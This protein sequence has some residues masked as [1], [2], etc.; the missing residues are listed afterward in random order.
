MIK[1]IDGVAEV[2]GGVLLL[3][4]SP[5]S[6]SRAVAALTQHELSEDPRDFI[7]TDLLRAANEIS[8]K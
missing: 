5:E 2:L 1:G 4:V 6:I 8:H 7:A 3:L